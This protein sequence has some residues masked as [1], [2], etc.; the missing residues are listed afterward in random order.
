MTETVSKEVANSVATM[1]A[2]L[3]QATK[4]RAALAERIGR[5]SASVF[6]KEYLEDNGLPPL[7]LELREQL[8]DYCEEPTQHLTN[9]ELNGVYSN[10]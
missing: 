2:D 10:D 9:D 6:I 7:P 5:L 8:V 4:V 3:R 1:V